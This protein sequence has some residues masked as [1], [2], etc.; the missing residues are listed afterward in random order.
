MRD[1][2][3]II[4]R[5]EDKKEPLRFMGGFFFR[6]NEPVFEVFEEGEGFMGVLG[7]NDYRQLRQNPATK[8]WW[9]LDSIGT[10]F[11][12]P[13]NHYLPFFCTKHKWVSYVI[14]KNGCASLLK[15]ALWYDGDITLQQKND[16]KFVWEHYMQE[17]GKH[18]VGYLQAKN[19]P[20]DFKKFIVLSDP[21]E[22]VVR[23][24]NW[25]YRFKYNKWYTYDQPKEKLVEELIWSLQLTTKHPFKS[26]SHVLPQSEF[27]KNI[28]K[29]FYDGDS[30]LFDKEVERVDL[31][32]LQEFYRDT[33]GEPFVLNNISKPEDRVFSVSDLTPELVASLRD[34]GIS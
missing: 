31:K 6:G 16:N 11:I 32:N 3:F 30:A 28:T 29:L 1:G 14:G 21:I 23:W 26:D 5:I 24:M 20:K 7:Q 25:V 15:S 12:V 18:R 27:I 2:D 4:L 19:I 34:I 8:E 17:C 13:K 9:L 10:P 33:F 22:R